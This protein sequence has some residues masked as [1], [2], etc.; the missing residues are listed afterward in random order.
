[1]TGFKLDERIRL[2]VEL[3]LT[4]TS[5]DSLL[6]RK[7]EESARAIGMTGAEIDVARRGFSFDVKTSMAIALALAVCEENRQRAL[8]TGLCAR[9]CAEIEKMAAAFRQSGSRPTAGF[10]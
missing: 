1:M 6:L 3:A 5:N 9:S 2:P 7:Q 10:T 4:A 8:R